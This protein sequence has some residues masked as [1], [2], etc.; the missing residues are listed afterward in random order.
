MARF[1]LKVNDSLEDGGE[2]SG[3]FGHKGRPGMQG[4]SGEGSGSGAM[5]KSDPTGTHYGMK[6]NEFNR[7]IRNAKSESE[8][9][10]ALL[11]ALKMMPR[12]MTATMSVNGENAEVRRNE[13][14]EYT[15]QTFGLFGRTKKMTPEQIVNASSME[16]FERPQFSEDSLHDAVSS[17]MPLVKGEYDGFPGDD[18]DDGGPGSGNWGHHGRPGLRGGSGKGG[19]AEHSGQFGIKQ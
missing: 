18:V 11:T 15:V 13:K 1:L 3:N 5:E 8:G 6:A 12:D 4:G 10:K 2:G 9:K 19:G 7:A 16:V 17:I 14:G